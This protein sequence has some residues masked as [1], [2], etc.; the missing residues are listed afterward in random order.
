MQ[1]TLPT[2]TC[3]SAVAQALGTSARRTCRITQ[4]SMRATGRK[5]N[6]TVRDKRPSLEHNVGTGPKDVIDYLLTYLLY[7]ILISNIP[8]Y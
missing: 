7:S 3:G 5:E 6:Q 2:T 8:I 4:R 1:I